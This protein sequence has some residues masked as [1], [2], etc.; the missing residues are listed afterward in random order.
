MQE[1]ENKCTARSWA[2]AMIPQE[3]AC[4]RVEVWLHLTLS[5]SVS[6]VSLP[7]QGAIGSPSALSGA[8]LHC[9]VLR[10][11][12]GVASP[13]F[14]PCVSKNTQSCHPP[15]LSP[16]PGWWC[17]PRNSSVLWRQKIA[18]TADSST[19]HQTHLH[20]GLFNLYLHWES[21]CNIY[22]CT[23]DLRR[24]GKKRLAGL[25]YASLGLVSL[26]NH[27]CIQINWYVIEF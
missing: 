25:L 1:N 9:C 16:P 12:P 8:C 22:Y 27:F 19:S 24:K 14:R 4:C 2:R 7:S 3:G 20:H 5:F 13:R 17:L 15:P 23:T 11:W 21:A 18:L 26:K 10:R 6:M